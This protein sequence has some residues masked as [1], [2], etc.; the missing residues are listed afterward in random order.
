MPNF[1]LSKE[2]IAAIV[3]AIHLVQDSMYDTSNE[4]AATG[5]RE[6]LRA[7]QV[8]ERRLDRYDVIRH[9]LGDTWQPSKEYRCPDDV[10]ELTQ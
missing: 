8:I 3:M 2:E 9:K 4:L 5:N 1:D 10:R 7:S 6:D